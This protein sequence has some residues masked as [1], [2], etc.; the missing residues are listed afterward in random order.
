LVTKRTKNLRLPRSHQIVVLGIMQPRII[1]DLLHIGKADLSEQADHRRYR[2]HP[3]VEIEVIGLLALVL[4]E[5]VLV[6]FLKVVPGKQPPRDRL[7]VRGGNTEDPAR[8]KH[9]E[10]LAEDMFIVVPA[11]V[12]ERGAGDDLGDHTAFDGE[13]P[14]DIEDEVHL[15]EGDDVD[16]QVL[17]GLV[18]VSPAADIQFRPL[19][20]LCFPLLRPL[21]ALHFGTSILRP[22]IEEAEAADGTVVAVN[23]GLHGN[24][25]EETE[26][27]KETE[28]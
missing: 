4:S 10:E 28:E 13:L 7:D 12:L 27:L 14:A 9:A 6:H 1:L 20:P 11:E 2:V 5:E 21:T 3:P 23:E 8:R 22:A 24:M 26:E 17:P 16:I 18:R 15:R 25:I 19:V